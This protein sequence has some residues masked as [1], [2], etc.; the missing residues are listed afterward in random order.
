M[1]YNLC[2]SNPIA[3]RLPLCKFLSSVAFDS[4]LEMR[5]PVCSTVLQKWMWALWTL[6]V[7]TQAEHND[8]TTRTWD[9]SLRREITF[10][11]F[12]VLWPGKNI[13]CAV[14]ARKEPALGVAYM[15]A[16]ER[17]VPIPSSFLCSRLHP[18]G[19][20]PFFE[21]HV[22]V[23]LLRLRFFLV[24]RSWILWS[25]FQSALFSSLVPPA[26]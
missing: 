25:F 2:P 1:I 24:L 4:R 7:V 17:C 22:S 5:I 14:N 13:I 9:L 8:D 6:V 20:S 11:S 10:Y 19:R 23:V 21:L 15:T 12:W 26:L 18:A 16:D 3:D